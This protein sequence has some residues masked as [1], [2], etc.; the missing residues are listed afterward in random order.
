MIFWI[1]VGIALGY[2]FKPQ[3]DRVV[4]KLFKA[5]RDGRNGRRDRDRWDDRY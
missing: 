3:L 1:I 2:F 4:G 5:I